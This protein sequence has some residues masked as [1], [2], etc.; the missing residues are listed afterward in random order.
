[1]KSSPLSLF[2]LRICMLIA[3]VSLLSVPTAVVAASGSAECP[4]GQ[5]VSCAAYRCDC[6]DNVGC[7]GYDSNGNVMGGQTKAC[8]AATHDLPEDAPVS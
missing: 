7:T 5:T 2:L 4:G 8:P 3:I 1:M 6:I